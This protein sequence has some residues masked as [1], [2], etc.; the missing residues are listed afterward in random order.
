[1]HFFIYYTKDIII[2]RQKKKIEFFII[3]IYYYFMLYSL[4]TNTPS[5]RRAGGVNIIKRTKR[6][7]TLPFFVKYQG[8]SRVKEHKLK[9]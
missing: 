1:M 6:V 8:R 4:N 9:I 2:R 7:C 5:M 3:I